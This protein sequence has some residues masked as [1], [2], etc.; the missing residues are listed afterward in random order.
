M[1]TALTPALPHGPPGSDPCDRTRPDPGCPDWVLMAEALTVVQTKGLLELRE[2]RAML[3]VCKQWK[4][5]FGA[6]KRRAQ[7][8]EIIKCLR[9]RG[10]LGP[11]SLHQ[12]RLVSNH[13]RVLVDATVKQLR[14]DVGRMSTAATLMFPQL[15]HLTLEDHRQSAAFRADLIWAPAGERLR[16]EAAANALMDVAVLAHPSL[17]HVRTLE[18]ITCK[19]DLF[20]PIPPGGAA[21]AG[22]LSILPR[23]RTLRLDRCWVPADPG[24]VAQLRELQEL[25]MQSCTGANYGLPLAQWLSVLPTS[26]QRLGL[27]DMDPVPLPPNVSVLTGLQQLRFS[28]STLRQPLPVDVGALTRLEVGADSSTRL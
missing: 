19:G 21:A 20:T 24:W 3:L 5:A 23:L 25:Q 17:A 10:H 11:E 15:Q 26:F 27:N 9:T 28:G 1:M 2:M 4:E 14:V 18:A 8:P 16:A 7:L 6:L 13:W 12:M 22:Q